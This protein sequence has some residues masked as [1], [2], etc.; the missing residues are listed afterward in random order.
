M[1]NIQP[2]TLSDEELVRYY[3]LWLDGDEPIPI[4]WQAE[5]LRRFLLKLNAQ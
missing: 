4:N 2:R 1:Q 3:A 5:L